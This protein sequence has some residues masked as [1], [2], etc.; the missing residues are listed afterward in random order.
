MPTPATPQT[1]KLR[2]YKA[3]ASPALDGLTVTYVQQELR[4][5]ETVIKVQN[6]VMVQLEARLAA[7]GA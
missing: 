6:Q 2:P 3:P 1:N 7:I 5:L 4:K